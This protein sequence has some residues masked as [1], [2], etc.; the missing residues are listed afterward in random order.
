[1][2]CDLLNGLEQ[3]T[4]FR[5]DQNKGSKMNKQSESIAFKFGC[6]GDEERE[7]ISNIAKV[8]KTNSTMGNM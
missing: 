1:L 8:L 2:E 7:A 5:R 6:L 3:I 4:E